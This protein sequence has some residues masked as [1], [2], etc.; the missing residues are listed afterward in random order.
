MRLGICAG[1]SVRSPGVVV[2]GQTEQEWC[3]RIVDQAAR[4][5]ARRGW[6][7]LDPR[8]DVEP[9]G[10]PA[11]LLLR[12]A[13]YEAERPD[14][15]IDVHLNASPDPS[16][17]YSVV[18]YHAPQEAAARLARAISG[19]FIRGLPWPSRGALPDEMLGRRLAF[20]RRIS[21]PAV[22][23]EP[24]FL[25]NPDARAWLQEPDGTATL[26]RL[27]VEGAE[28]WHVRRGS[29][30]GQSHGADR[31]PEDKRQV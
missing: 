30:D 6:Q 22:I 31:R 8:A 19:A 28:S 14:C 15:A 20:V 23:V 11:Y 29:E 2:E 21:V 7:V 24:L 1:H 27:I 5:A 25:T 18:V 3:R 10:Y 4:G 13:T 17:S 26:A 16:A 12:I 9:I